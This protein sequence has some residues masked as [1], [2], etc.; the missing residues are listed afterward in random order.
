[1]DKSK[2]KR[3][4][5]EMSRIIVFFAESAD[6]LKAVIFPLIQNVCFMKVTLEDLQETIN[7]EGATEVYQNGENQRGIKQSAA[8]Q[9]YNALVKNYT[10][11][12]KTLSS[13]LPSSHRQ[14]EF[15]SY[16]SLDEKKKKEDELKAT[17]RE[18]MVREAERWARNAG[19]PL[20]DCAAQSAFL[21]P[22]EQPMQQK[23]EAPEE[24]KETYSVQTFEEWQQEQME[25]K[26]QQEEKEK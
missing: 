8:L 14:I 16:R 23:E 17:L 20:D 4:Y 25:R 3:I 5:E 11:A 9:S 18:E 15:G 21:P 12:V 26:R 1:M 6:N 19:V 2:E 13:Y 24:K 10:S 7:E 22:V